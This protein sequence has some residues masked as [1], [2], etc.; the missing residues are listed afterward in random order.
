MIGF[1]GMFFLA[2]Q[3]TVPVIWRDAHFDVRNTTN[4]TYAKGLRCDDSTA[5]QQKNCTA[6]SL[7][8]D[9][10]EP[11][12]K[13]DDSVRRPAYILSHGGGNSGGVKEQYCFQGSAEFFASR[14]FVA[15]NIDY[16]L[17]GDHGKLPAPPAE[18]EDWAPSWA[19]GYPAVRDL[20]AAIR[21]V[22]ASAA[23]YGIDP[24]RIVVSG[25]SA[26]ATN[27]VAA[28]VTFDG[29]YRDELTVDEDPTLSTTHLEQ[30]DKVQCVVS[31]WASDGEIDLVTKFDP[32]KRSRYSAAN[33]PIVEFHGTNDTTIPIE[34]ARAVQQEYKKTGV[35]YELHALE[36]CPHAAWCYDG[37]GSCGVAAC[38]VARYDPFMDR[39]TLPFVATQLKLPLE[40]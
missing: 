21:F 5:G 10:Y 32:K 31:H 6:M 13:G 35:P 26:G 1:G 20:K 8:L 36:G 9:V 23:T 15:F 4:V 22:R 2:A 3:N 16:R 27:S 11:V 29:D 24:T 17:A 14:G 40:G 34:H 33:A 7:M 38:G 28:G 18:S 19:S 25:G 12:A 39:L 37:K 30:S